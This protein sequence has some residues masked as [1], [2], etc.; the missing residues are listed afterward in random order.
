MFS[1]FCIA[2][3]HWFTTDRLLIYSAFCADFG[4][5][6]LSAVHRFCKIMRDKMASK[7]LKGKKIVCW[8]GAT[9]QLRT[10]CVFLLGSYLCTELD[11]TPE[12][13]C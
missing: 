9:P 4:P 6:N 13:V 10:N 3:E 11:Y 1:C 8:T 2:G 7:E 5:M 12:Q